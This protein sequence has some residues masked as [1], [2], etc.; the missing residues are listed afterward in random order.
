MKNLSNF[1]LVLPDGE[2]IN[3]NT[4]VNGKRITESKTLCRLIKS[5]W[6]KETNS[7]SFQNWVDELNE[8]GDYQ[9]TFTKED[10]KE[11]MFGMFVLNINKKHYDLRKLWDETFEQVEA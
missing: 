2:A 6:K 10:A 7:S 9:S 4:L 5:I 1:T 11:N 3:Q 8:S